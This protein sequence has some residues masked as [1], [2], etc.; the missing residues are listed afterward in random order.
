M[1]TIIFK[2]LFME[3][4]FKSFIVSIKFIELVFLNS[5]GFN[6]LIIIYFIIVNMGCNTC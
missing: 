4:Y 5:K 1:L 6:F 3:I 2:I